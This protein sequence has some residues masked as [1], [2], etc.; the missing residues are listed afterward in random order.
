ML[1]I[2]LVGTGAFARE[3]AQALQQ[4]P[5]VTIRYVVGSDPAHTA[6]FAA[7]IPHAQP[8]TNLDRVLA[9][10]ELVAVDICNRTAQHAPATLAALRAGKHV[11]VDKPAALSVADFDAMTAA[12]ERA[13]VSLMVGQTVRFQPI[14]AQ[15]QAR[16]REL[17]APRLLHVSWYTGHV[18]PGGWRSWQ[19]DPAQ[20][21]GHPVHN[22]THIMD[23]AVWLLGAE[24]V[25][26]LTRGFNT[27]A[28]RM[29]QPDSFTSV[30][31]F[32]NGAL[33]TLE[34]CY[35]LR[36]RGDALRRVVLVGE[37]GTLKHSTEDDPGLSAPGVKVPPASILGAL[38]RQLAHWIAVVT[39]AESLLVQPQQVRAALRGAL[40]AQQSLVTGAPVR[41]EPNGVTA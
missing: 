40:A 15:L 8:S 35:A 20:S 9:D 37:R 6:S 19:L 13:G 17:G 7:T 23:L 41:L 31:R 29:P 18:W 3:H 39:G 30:V 26:V 4:L 2:A 28:A 11:H 36:E 14:I 21:G 32:D 34:L 12:A 22:G 27:F 16:S 5:E 33:A 25:E 1:N 10:P 24:P 38:D